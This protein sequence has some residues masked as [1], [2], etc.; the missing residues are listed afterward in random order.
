M[1]GEP[2]LQVR[3]VETY[4]GNIIALRGI[5]VEVRAGEIVTL[6]ALVAVAP[7]GSVTVTVTVSV[8]TAVLAPV[9]AAACRLVVVGV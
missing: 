6:T 7:C 3:G 4:Y 9:F 5:D 2:L 8:V 1:S